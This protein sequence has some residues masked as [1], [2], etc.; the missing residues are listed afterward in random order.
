MVIVL[1]IMVVGITIVTMS[2][3][4]VI[5][6]SQSMGGMMETHRISA[7]VEGGVENAIL[8]ILRNP[9]YAGE[10]LSIDGMPVTVTVVQGA[11]T[12]ITATA[13]SG[14]Y[15]QRY[16]VVLERISGVLTIV[17]WQHID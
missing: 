6:T 1:V 14:V 8:N 13:V 16:Q 17:S 12:T 11:Q 5:S 10:T 7:A 9:T 4:L 2:L 15:R 3:A